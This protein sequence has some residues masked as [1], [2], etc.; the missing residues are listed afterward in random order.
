ME[1]PN[2]GTPLTAQVKDQVKEQTQHVKEQ[3]QQAVQQGQQAAGRVVDQIKGQIKTRVSGGK[4]QI[5]SQVL[6]V[7]DAFRLLGT[8]LQEKGSGSVTPYTNQIADRISQVGETLQG[9][10]I[11]QL[12]AETEDFARSQ[13]ML[14][15]GTAIALGLFTARFL[16]SSGRTAGAVAS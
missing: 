15:I 6:D 5:A 13:P 4:D 2:S 16:K 7:A 12:V 3:T 11:D 14:F 9:K 8:Q 1:E 10:E